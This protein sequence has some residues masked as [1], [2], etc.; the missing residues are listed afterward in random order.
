LKTHA[1]GDPF[2]RSEFDANPARCAIPPS[3]AA[4]HPPDGASFSPQTSPNGLRQWNILTSF[5]ANGAADRPGQL[6]AGSLQHLQRIVRIL[7]L[8]TR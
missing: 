3:R 7:Q 8:I 2:D 1:S 4:F 6:Q 5:A